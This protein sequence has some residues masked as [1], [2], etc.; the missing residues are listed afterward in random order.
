MR[1]CWLLRFRK[2]SGAAMR[3]ARFA[4]LEAE[5][6]LHCLP[7]HVT[8]TIFGCGDWRTAA[9]LSRLWTVQTSVH[10]LCTETLRAA[11]IDEKRAA[12]GLKARAAMQLSSCGAER[13]AAG[14]CRRWEDAT[15][16]EQGRLVL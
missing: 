13:N 12:A 10:S 16:P 1:S 4:G 15:E 2:T 11:G 8:L 3:Q 14:T 5:S 9:S 7:P 6:F